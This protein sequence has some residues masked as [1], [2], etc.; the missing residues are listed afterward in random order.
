MVKVVKVNERL[1]GC[2]A[3][4][5]PFVFNALEMWWQ[6]TGAARFMTLSTF[7]IYINM[8]IYALSTRLWTNYQKHSHLQLL[9]CFKD[10]SWSVLLFRPEIN[11]NSSKF[12]QIF[13]STISKTNNKYKSL[14]SCFF[15]PF[16]NFKNLSFQTV[17]R[18][19]H[20]LRLSDVV[21]RINA[22]FVPDIWYF[23]AL[24]SDA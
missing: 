5:R 12:K 2:L 16:F 14:W 4:V 18:Y 10:L 7:Q 20:I 1:R 9:F 15:F 22:V 11:Y 23:C 21:S 6:S 17:I 24:K 13:C 8:N 19:E 3:V